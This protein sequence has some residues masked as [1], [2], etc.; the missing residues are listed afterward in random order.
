MLK[1]VTHLY[2]YMKE[3]PMKKSFPTVRKT[4]A[5][6]LNKNFKEK[7]KNEFFWNFFDVLRLV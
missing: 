2:H 6:I 5:K 3:N 7:T 1:R 4:I